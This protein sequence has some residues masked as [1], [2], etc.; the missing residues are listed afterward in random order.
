MD[1]RRTLTVALVVL[2]GLSLVAGTAAAD[3]RVGGTVSVPEGETVDDLTV[4]SGTTTIDGTV[5][6]DLTVLGGTVKINGV[7]RGDVTGVAGSVDVFGYVHGDVS[8]AAGSIVIEGTVGDSVNVGAGTLDIR[9]RATIDGDVNYG[10]DLRVDDGATIRGAVTESSWSWGPSWFRGFFHWV[11]VFYLTLLHLV[12]GAILLLVAP[13]FTDGVADAVA[14]RPARSLA[15]GLALAVGSIGAFVL[16]LLTIVGIPLALFGL[17]FALVAYWIALVYGR[18][19][20]GAWVLSLT[21]AD[22]RWLALL[23]GVVGVSLLA[24]V[25][26]VGW[27]LSGVVT[28]LGLGAM[29]A[30]VGR[31]RRER[32]A[33][34]A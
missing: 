12:I 33:S 9:S 31:R 2:L 27:L 16:L 28:L 8:M 22:S 18:Y 19:A 14:D 23:V 24:Q 30:V 5:D 21:D 34:G 20:V 10:G 32:R 1:G 13:R 29:G 4:V 25:P 6:G 17:L 26:L 3:T 7:V 15:Y 11:G